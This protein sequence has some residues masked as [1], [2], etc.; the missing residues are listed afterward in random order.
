M[1]FHP[2]SYR[3]ELAQNQQE[4]NTTTITISST[5]TAQAIT[6]TVTH[7]VAGLFTG[8]ETY[9]LLLG[10]PT[11]GFDDTS[12]YH[13]GTLTRETHDDV[14]TLR[15]YLVAPWSLMRSQTLVNSS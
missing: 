3:I 4:T 14:D 2:I 10:L 6:S 8:Q 7:T 5:T 9:W 12:R 15:F 13:A 1:C 11:I